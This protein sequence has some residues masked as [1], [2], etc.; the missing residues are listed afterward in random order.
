[1]ATATATPVSAQIIDFWAWFQPGFWSVT[2]NQKS[3]LE[4]SGDVGALHGAQTVKTRVS[5]SKQVVVSSDWREIVEKG[6]SAITLQTKD[7]VRGSSPLEHRTTQLVVEM[8][9]RLARRPRT[10]DVESEPT[11]KRSNEI[12]CRTRRRSPSPRQLGTLQR[13][14]VLPDDRQSDTRVHVSNYL[15]ALQIS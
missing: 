2:T 12:A 9:E 11:P 8:K 1:M 7:L 10:N 5:E 4:L 3:E 15:V 14:Y 6:L 13:P